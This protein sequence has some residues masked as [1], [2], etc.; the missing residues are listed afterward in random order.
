[1]LGAIETSRYDGEENEPRLFTEV[2]QIIST[3]KRLKYGSPR[4]Q[5]LFDD[6]HLVPRKTLLYLS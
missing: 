3:P 6:V 4:V 2:L 1:M 5:A